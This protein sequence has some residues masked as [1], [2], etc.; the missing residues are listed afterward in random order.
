MKKTSKFFACLSLSLLT[1]G[2]MAQTHLIAPG[3]A[4]HHTARTFS[5]R[6]SYHYRDLSRS[7]VALTYFNLNY[8]SA[9]AITNSV[10]TH[11]DYQGELMNSNYVYPADTAGGNYNVINYVTVAFDSLFDPYQLIDTSYAAIAARS[12]VLVVD[13]IVFPF[14]Q[15]NHSGTNDTIDISLNMVNGTPNTG[16]PLATVI[17]DT[18]IIGQQLGL[19]SSSL[20]NI[21][22][23]GVGQELSDPRFSVTV[24]Y[25]GSKMDSCYFLYGFA[26][27][28]GSCDGGTF[29]LANAT[30]WSPID[31]SGSTPVPENSFVLYNEYVAYG[32]L[33]DITGAG[34][35]YDCNGDG[36]YDAGDGGPYEEN[37]YVWALVHTAANVA[38]A[39]NNI[40]ASGFSVKQNYPNPFNKTTQISYSLTKS[41]DVTF[42]VYDMTGREIMT[43]NYN[44]V[45]PGNHAINLSANSF[46]PG[47]YFYT[48]TIGG[49]KVTNKM[50]ITE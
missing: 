6:P 37:I 14:V 21:V 34:L 45:T 17:K 10:T 50:V 23:W 2:A 15:V 28:N 49:T 22:K 46:S 41:A 12:E 26:G 35:F 48:F 43:T 31:V 38:T 18:L 7:L 30:T 40:S 36:T 29:T 4:K 25:K 32:Q 3:G 5:N 44:T 20:I 42:S 33:P 13:T 39:V 8:D 9:D 16:Y 47:V 27:F 11:Y 24:T 1:V 19:G